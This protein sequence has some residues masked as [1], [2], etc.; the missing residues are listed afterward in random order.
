[1]VAADES[2]VVRVI[3]LLHAQEH[4]FQT[5]LIRRKSAGTLAELPGPAALHADR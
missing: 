2:D 5:D 3:G 4:F 1:M